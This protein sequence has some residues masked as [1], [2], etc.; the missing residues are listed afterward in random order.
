MTLDSPLPVRQKGSAIFPIFFRMPKARTGLVALTVGA[1]GVVYGDIGT[2]P[3]YTVN[4]IFRNPADFAPSAA[5][6]L[7]ALS[8]IFWALTLLVCVEYIGFVL[9]A[10]NNGEGGVFALLALLGGRKSRKYKFLIAI[11]LL[12]AGFLYG[13]GMITPAI[14]VLSA[15]EGLKVATSTFDPFVVPLTLIILTVLFAFQWKGTAK[16]GAVFGP[17]MIVW[18]VGIGILGLRQIVNY[19]QIFIALNPLYALE[20]FREA[21]WHTIFTVL[22]SVMLAVTGGE[23]LYADL[24]HFGRTPIRYGWLLLVFPCLLLNYFGQGAYILSGQAIL[25]S[26]VF[27]SLVPRLLL[28]PMVVMATAATII[29]SQAL[30][31]GVFSLTSQA[32]QMGLLPKFTTVHTSSDHHGQI[33][34]PTLNWFLYVGCVLLV[35][36]FHSSSNLAAA[37]GL[38]VS[39]LMCATALSMRYVARDLWHWN[40]AWATLVFGFFTAFCGMFLVA[41][42]IKFFHGGY[43]PLLIGFLF[44]AG[45]KI[46]SRA[47]DRIGQAA[48]AY[49]DKTVAWVKEL[50]DDPNVPDLPRGLVFFTSRPVRSMKDRVSSTFFF[51][52][53]KYGALPAHLLFFHAEESTEPYVRGKNRFEHFRIADRV[54]AVVLHYGFME[55]ADVR[56]ALRELEKMKKLALPAD[57]WIIELRENQTIVSGKAPWWFKMRVAVY[58]FLNQLAAPEHNIF[59][60][61]RDAG[62]SYQRLPIE[63]TPDRIHFRFPRWDIPAPNQSLRSGSG[64]KGGMK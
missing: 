56:T 55:K 49:V 24:G 13:D 58:G 50:R 61:G 38:A 17:V 25:Q 19:P 7:Q 22:G 28:Y 35:I 44:F 15:V 45:M 11:L 27:Y 40:D 6:A 31:T 51:F 12:S 4:E 10:D 60:M 52:F 26:D 23:A 32:S 2:S 64:Q 36:S 57:Q 53:N 14:S 5:H 16:V 20:F 3:L 42:S 18:F 34:L 30:I 39:V 43:L 1:I 8:M 48:D 62:I 54:D 9:Q 33:Y 41:N 59:E 63:F 37:Y 46:W 47:K 29:A 21:Q